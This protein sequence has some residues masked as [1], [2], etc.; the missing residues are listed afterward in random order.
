MIID[1]NS[2]YLL[3]INMELWEV[4]KSIILVED[5]KLWKCI[6]LLKDQ[7]WNYILPWC[8]HKVWEKSNILWLQETLSQQLFRI[9]N[10][11]LKIKKCE[12]LINYKIDDYKVN[13]YNV[14]FDNRDVW[15]SNDFKWFW[16]YPIESRYIKERNALELKMK[17]IDK[18]WIE[19]LKNFNLNEINVLNYWIYDKLLSN[20]RKELKELKKVLKI[21]KSA[22]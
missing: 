1:V 20:F 10:Y 3:P 12:E 11:P 4:S 5:F 13:L 18:K 7:E 8:L 17:E 9:I 6:F 22:I 21:I 19:N 14:L 15:L 2:I 16:L